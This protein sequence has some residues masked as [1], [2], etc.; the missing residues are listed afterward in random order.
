[1]I[2][3][4]LDNGWTIACSERRDGSFRHREQDF[5]AMAQAPES[6]RFCC[7]NVV[8]GADVVHASV[9]NE[10]GFTYTGDGLIGESPFA[11]LGVSVGDC[12]PII[13]T[14]SKS[15]VGAVVHGGWR[16]LVD[17]VL[18]NT[19][20]SLQDRYVLQA[21]TL[22]VWIGPCI[23]GN[24]YRV[25]EKPRQIDR[26]DWK[27]AIRQQEYHWSIDLPL[28]VRQVVNRFGISNEQIFDSELDTFTRPDQFF[29]HRRA[30]ETGN[31]EDDGRFV[32]VAW[33]QS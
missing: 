1:M 15:S 18:E 32:V 13:I 29:S 25:E 5:L 8:H 17:G 26:E 3:F 6:H 11:I 24:S 9:H 20:R 7:L 31:A 10:R 28:Y 27:D 4:S 19:L 14:D 2:L 22:R 33:R 21:E 30:Q 16:S 23:R 12:V